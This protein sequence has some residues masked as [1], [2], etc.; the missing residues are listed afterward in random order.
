MDTVLSDL[1]TVLFFLLVVR[2]VFNWL[3]SGNQRQWKITNF[4]EQWRMFPI[5]MRIQRGFPMQ[6]CRVSQLFH[7]GL[8]LIHALPYLAARVPVVF[9]GFSACF[10]FIYRKIHGKT[11]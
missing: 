3:P 6:K 8:Q 5:Q 4:M 1:F 7:P 2:S 9:H 10:L 11:I